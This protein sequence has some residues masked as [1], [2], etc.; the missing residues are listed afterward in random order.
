VARA[1]APVLKEPWRKV[2]KARQVLVEPAMG[3]LNA[4]LDD[5]EAARAAGLLHHL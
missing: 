1:K 2:A 5:L 3:V 4:F